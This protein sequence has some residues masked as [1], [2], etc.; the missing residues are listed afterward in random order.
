MR[1]D[2]RRRELRESNSSPADDDT[3]SHNT[4]MQ[5]DIERAMNQLPADCRAVVI[6]CLAYGFSHSE[7]AE[8]TNMALGTVKSHAARGKSKLR[9]FLSAYEK[10][11]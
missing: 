2:I 3:A 5:M 7:A 10:A 11:K 6:L 8:A 4:A 9:A 1:K